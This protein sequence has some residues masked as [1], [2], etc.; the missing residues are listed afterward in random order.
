MC[1]FFNELSTAVGDA[2]RGGNKVAMSL[3]KYFK[4]KTSKTV[5]VTKEILPD[6]SGSLSKEVLLYTVAAANETAETLLT[7]SKK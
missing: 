2:E 4:T 3:L 6:P 5:D 1:N 7:A